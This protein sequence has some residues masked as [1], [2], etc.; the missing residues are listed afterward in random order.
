MDP[1]FAKTRELL[2]QL[3]VADIIRREPIVTHPDQMMSELRAILRDRRISGTPVVEDGRVVGII[4]IEDL[5]GWLSSGGQ[6]CPI[7]EKMT[8]DPEV[9]YA[10]QLLVQTIQHFDA[11]G[12]GRFPV[13]DRRD[14]SLIGIMTKGAIIEGLL[15]K[16]E[17]ALREEEIR[18]YRASHIFEDLTAEYKEIYLTYEVKG[19]DFDLAGKASTQMK[20]NLKRLG[21]HPDIAHRLAIASYE[22]EMNVVIYADRGV[23]EYRITPQEVSLRIRDQGPGIADIEKAMRPGYST[24]ADWVRELGFGA[25]MGLQNIKKCADRMDLRSTPGVGTTLKIR[26]F[27]RKANETE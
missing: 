11:S 23:M 21:I 15:G 9:L 22:A 25:G 17:H 3:R 12:F 26:I 10:D 5:I 24:A 27:T 1:R 4:S 13:I 7:R 2:Y 6:D 8:R 16:L 20:R 19:K 18:Q 14:G